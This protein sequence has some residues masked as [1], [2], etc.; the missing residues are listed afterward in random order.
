MGVGCATRGALSVA[1][2]SG[3]G[4]AGCGPFGLHQKTS[5]QVAESG[6]NQC[7]RRRV[8]RCSR[9]RAFI[10]LLASGLR[11]L[12]SSPASAPQRRDVLRLRASWRPLVMPHRVPQNPCGWGSCLV[13]S[14]RASHMRGVGNKVACRLGRVTLAL[15]L[16]VVTLPCV[17]I[18]RIVTVTALRR[19]VHW[20]R[21]AFHGGREEAVGGVAQTCSST[22]VSFL[23]YAV[24]AAHQTMSRPGCL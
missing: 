22:V 24:V 19:V 1:S 17:S 14:T 16:H 21:C 7:F 2:P 13:L 18:L 12:A 15:L 10:C 20:K 11:T 5:A 23:T 8:N 4:E 3:R 9:P 6:G